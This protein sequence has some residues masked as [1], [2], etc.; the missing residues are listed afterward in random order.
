VRRNLC[1]FAQHLR[2]VIL[3]ETILRRGFGARFAGFSACLAAARV[4]GAILG[5]ERHKSRFF[6]KALPE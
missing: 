2:D 6:A 5:W 3:S 1:H 4:S